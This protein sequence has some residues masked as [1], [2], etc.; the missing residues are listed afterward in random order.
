MVV[1][2][3]VQPA[4]ITT[5]VDHAKERVFTRSTA[6]PRLIG[7]EGVAADSA[8]GQVALEDLSISILDH[9]EEL[10]KCGAIQEIVEATTP[11]LS[12]DL[13]DALALG[14]TLLM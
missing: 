1:D 4:P 10:S 9:S 8:N 13:V 14:I 3:N 12:G 5:F 11:G 7:L 6:C 2:S